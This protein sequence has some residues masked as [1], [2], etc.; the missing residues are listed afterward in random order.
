MRVEPATLPCSFWRGR[1]LVRQKENTGWNCVWTILKHPT[2]QFSAPKNKRTPRG[3]VSWLWLEVRWVKDVSL[4]YNIQIRKLQNDS[5]K[6][7]I[8]PSKKDSDLSGCHIEELKVTQ[9]K[10]ESSNKQWREQINEKNGW[11]N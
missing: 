2:L 1:F 11:L 4:I 8:K 10:P 9:R 5:L 6:D 3:S 7:T